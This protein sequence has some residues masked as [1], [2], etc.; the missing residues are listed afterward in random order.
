MINFN[1]N[2]RKIVTYITLF[3]LFISF[4]SCGGGGGDDPEPTP[5]TTPPTASILIFPSENSACTEGTNVSETES[6]IVF[7]WNASKNTDSYSLTIK[8]LNTQKTVSHTSSNT[9]LSVRLKIATPYSWTIISKS[10]H[11]DK[12]ATSNTWKFYN[13]GAGTTTH[14]PFPAEV[15]APVSGANITSNTVNLDWEATDIDGDISTY[16]VYFGTS[17]NPPKYK[18]GITESI[19][20]EITVTAGNTYYWKVNTIDEQGN[21][22]SSALFNFRVN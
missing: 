11:S 1:K 8:N 18:D 3:C 7:E 14:A 5:D 6:S 15:V 10:N 22:S 13:A 19:L 4:T 12:N 2:N 20:N 16:E 21:I 17:N 9:S